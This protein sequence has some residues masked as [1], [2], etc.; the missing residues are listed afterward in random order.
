[1]SSVFWGQL[2]KPIAYEENGGNG[3]T[4]RD[5]DGGYNEVGAVNEAAR[6][7]STATPLVGDAVSPARG[8]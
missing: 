8:G 6:Q 7:N 4:Q 5:D 2:A 1:M 3:T